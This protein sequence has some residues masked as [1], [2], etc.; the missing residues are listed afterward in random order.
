MEPLKGERGNACV[1]KALGVLAAVCLAVSAVAWAKEIRPGDLRVCGAKQCRVVN[2]PADARAFSA[3]LWGE[4]TL[5]RAPTPPVG[6]PVFELRYPDGPVGAIVSRTAI[7]VHGLNCGRFQ[8]GKWY[9]LPER[10]RRLTRGL[11][12]RALKAR[13]PRSC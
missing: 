2:D 3:L 10:L 1:L 4:G 11:E 8:R 13:V 7:R 5:P 12:T 9:R 6:S